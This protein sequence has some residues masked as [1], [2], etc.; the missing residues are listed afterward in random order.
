MEREEILAVYEAGSEAVIE[1]INNLTV[2]ILEQHEIIAI[3][4]KKI[5]ILEERIKTL[6]E[7]L[8]KNSRNSSKPPSTDGLAKKKP[9]TKSLRKKSGR[10]PGGQEGHPGTTLTMVEKPDK[11]ILYEVTTCNRC[12]LNIQDLEAEDHESRQVFEI[13]PIEIKVTEHCVEIKVCPKCGCTTK[14]DFPEDVKHVVQYGKNVGALSVYLHH[15]QLLPYER[16]CELLSDV[17]GCKISPA[18]LIR[19]E[20]DCFEKLE[21]FENEIKNHL[22]QS[23]V[24]HCDE[25]GMKVKGNRNWLHVASTDKLTYYTVHSKRGSEAMNDMDIL[26]NFSGISIHDYWKAYYKYNCKHSLCNDHHLRDLTGIY[27]NYDQQWSKNMVDLLIEIKNCVDKERETSDCLDTEI[28]RYFEAKYDGIIKIGLEENP[29]SLDF[30][31][32]PKKRGKKKQT[33]AKNLLDRFKNK[34]TDILRFMHDFT[35]PFGN[36]QA[37]RDVRMMK[38]QQKISG[39]F[40]SL[41]GAVNFCRIRGFISTTKKNKLSVINSIQDVFSG[42]PFVLGLPEYPVEE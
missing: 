25:T 18:T 16:S 27:E 3:Q 19:V 24:I 35:V 34:K 23:D 42:K 17:C 33:P 38:L 30:Q 5:A 20:N 36:S 39:T 41:Q 37:E 21:G 9:K 12:S 11:T 26:P 14:A 40:R 28:L 31:K 2:I 10:K 29:P 15:Y 4:A 7:Q 8:N 13:P 1:L 22:I 6:E 32:Q